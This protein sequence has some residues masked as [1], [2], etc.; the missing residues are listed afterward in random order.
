MREIAGEYILIPTGNHN[1]KIEGI[2][3]LTSV[4]ALIWESLCEKDDYQYVLQKIVDEYEVSEEE[5][6]KD[7]DELLVKMEETGLLL[8]IEKR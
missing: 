1:K 4:A 2:I 8:E 3:T 5:A 7:L 6:K